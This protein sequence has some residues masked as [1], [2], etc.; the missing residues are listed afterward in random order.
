ML[1]DHNSATRQQQSATARI[2]K[3]SPTQYVAFSLYSSLDVLDTP[4]I[5]PVP[6]SAGHCLGM[7][8][9]QRHWIP[10][11]DMAALLDGS[12]ALETADVSLVMVLL[13]T[14]EQASNPQHETASNIRMAAIALTETPRNITVHADQVSQQV[15]GNARL[16][17]MSLAGFQDDGVH[18]PIIST[19]KL[20]HVHALDFD[21]E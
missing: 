14:S 17:S 3:I 21:G 9:W 8:C 13:Y 10:L 12:D 16:Q 2:T 7:I 4:K 18:V 5:Y 15:S 20:F 19:D 11:I 6:A 1:F